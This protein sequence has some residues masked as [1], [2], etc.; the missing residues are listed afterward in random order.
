MRSTPRYPGPSRTRSRGLLRRGPHQAHPDICPGPRRRRLDVDWLTWPPRP[1]A[2]GAVSSPWRLRLR[3][4]TGAA[5]QPALARCWP[6]SAVDERSMTVRVW[7]AARGGPAPGPGPG[8]GVPRRPRT[9]FTVNGVARVS[10]A[11]PRTSVTAS[12]MRAASCQDR[13]R[14]ASSATLTRPLRAAAARAGRVRVVRRPG[15]AK[16][17][18]SWSSWMVHSTSDRPP[19]PSLTCRAAP[20]RAAC[21]RPPSGP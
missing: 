1:N 18:R 11:V 20:P 2:T 15:T 14:V 13:T 12:R 16:A 7:R 4:R 6:G 5:D 10:A 9:E 21:A 17:C 3:G 19:G 8:R